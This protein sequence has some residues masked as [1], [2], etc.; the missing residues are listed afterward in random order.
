MKRI[1]FSTVALF[2]TT[3]LFAQENA[4][5]LIYSMLKK[6]ETPHSY[7]IIFD[8]KYY[9]SSDSRLEICRSGDK[10]YVCFFLNGE[11]RGEDFFDGTDRYSIDHSDF[12][13]MRTGKIPPGDGDIYMLELNQEGLGYIDRTDNK[14]KKNKECKIGLYSLEEY[15]EKAPDQA[16]ITYTIDQVELV[17]KS[18]FWTKDRRLDLFLN[19]KLD[20]VVNESTFTPDLNKYKDYKMNDYRDL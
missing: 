4:N 9:K 11:L 8:K 18:V 13:I 3:I 15:P 19:F 16:P 6:L 2:A 1:I 7:E 20:I 10:T 17:P 5:S 14:A 12:T